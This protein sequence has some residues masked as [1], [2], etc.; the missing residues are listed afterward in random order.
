MEVSSVSSNVVTVRRGVGNSGVGVAILDNDELV[1]IGSAYPEGAASQSARS[2]KEVKNYNY[3][4]IQRT[5]IEETRT[6][7]KTEMWTENDWAFEV[8]KQGIEHLKKLE[9]M[10]W[11]GKREEGTDTTN[12]TSG[13]PKRYSGGIISQFLQTNRTAFSGTLT[14]SDFHS[15]LET[16]LKNGSSMKYLF[17]APRVLTVISNFAHGRLNTKI[18]DK[19][20]GVT[21]HEYQSPHGLVKLVRQSLFDEMT[22]YSGAGV[23][24]DL[25]NLKYRFLKDSDVSLKDNR[26][27]NDVDGRKSEYLS[28]SGIQMMLEKEAAMFTGVSN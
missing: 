3:L 16:G 7:S 11:F 25:K 27:A 23:L 18:D 13:K 21:I 4:Q 26:Q 17:C 22:Q 14:E 28:E 8:K 20:Y 1:V 10:F 12:N 2:T 6:Y 24:L 5:P 15:F 19:I 9:R